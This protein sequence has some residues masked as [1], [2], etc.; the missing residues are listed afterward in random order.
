MQ[1]KPGWLGYAQLGGDG[2]G[3]GVQWG[4]WSGRH[5]TTGDAANRCRATGEKESRHCGSRA[6]A[7]RDA[8]SLLYT[9]RYRGS[10]DQRGMPEQRQWQR[11][12]AGPAT[13][14]EVGC[15]GN[16]Q[17]W[18][19]QRAGESS[20]IV[21]SGIFCPEHS[22]VERLWLDMTDWTARASLECI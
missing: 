16:R 2:N 11:L 9:A 3:G 15:A 10:P 4:S 21:L 20:P 5:G 6:L 12:Q 19:G 22:V 13:R 18:T 17:E 14:G 7:K 1:V 8:R